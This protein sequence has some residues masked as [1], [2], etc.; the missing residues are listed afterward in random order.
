MSLPHDEDIFGLEEDDDTFLDLVGRLTP[1]W[2]RVVNIL[3][4][5]VVDV[6]ASEGEKA[7]L[8]LIEDISLIVRNPETTH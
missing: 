3:L 1:G 8:S 4:R 6:E 7:A 2:R 5:K